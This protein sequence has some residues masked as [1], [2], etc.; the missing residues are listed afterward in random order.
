MCVNI[1]NIIETLENYKKEH[2]NV[3]I[4][5]VTIP[6]SSKKMA[7]GLDIYNSDLYIPIYNTYNG[8]EK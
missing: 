8:G 1:S 4:S 6:S 5:G 3:I 2:G 7:F